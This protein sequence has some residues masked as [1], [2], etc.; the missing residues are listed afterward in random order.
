METRKITIVSTQSQ[1]KSVIMS[2]ATTLAELKDDLRANGI[3]YAGMTF[4][5]GLSK[6]ELLND[7]SLLPQNVSYKGT[8]TNELVFMLTNSEKKIRS[9]AEMSRAE[10]FNAIKENN[11]Q[12]E[13]KEKFGK[14]YTNCT[15]FELISFLEEKTRKNT[16][17]AEKADKAD[18]NT[19]SK[20]TKNDPNKEVALLKEAFV[21]LVNVLENENCIGEE[22]KDDILSILRGKV[23]ANNSSVYSDKEIDAMFDFV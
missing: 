22:D 5:E 17:E 20:S 18:K 2:A 8:T 7:D 23:A 11:L 10:A 9:G 15:T 3:S 4:Y 14:A 6:T 21:A 13:C 16:E 12:Q 19:K 1:K